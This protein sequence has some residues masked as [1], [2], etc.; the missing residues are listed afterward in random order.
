[1]TLLWLRN[2]PTM[3]F[4]QTMFDI[5]ERTLARV[6]K[7]TIR[8]LELTLEKEQVFG[9]EDELFDKMRDKDIGTALEKIVCWVDGTLVRTYRSMNKKSKIG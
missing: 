7:R 4:M 5:H 6:L 1:V 8:C 2:Y 9:D 3:H